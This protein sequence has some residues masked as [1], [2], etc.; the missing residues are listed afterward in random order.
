MIRKAVILA[1]G[2]SQRLFPLSLEIPKPLLTLGGQTLIE[3]VANRLRRF[4]CADTIYASVGYQSQKVSDQFVYVMQKANLKHG[5]FVD[6]TVPG[7]S[8][9]LFRCRDY[10]LTGDLAGEALWV[11]TV[12]NGI[13]VD[14][15]RAA[16]EFEKL[17]RP[18]CMIVPV[19][20]ESNDFT[21]DLFKGDDGSRISAISRRSDNLSASPNGLFMGSG[22]QLI[23][24]TRILQLVG[25]NSYNNFWELWQYLIEKGQLYVAKTTPYKWCKVD[26]LEDW[27]REIVSFAQGRSAYC[28]RD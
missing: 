9:W 6:E 4:A 28:T 12:D 8:Y 20:S 2:N 14:Y 5:V 25:E 21:G 7:T 17:N 26:T 24:P 13:Q 18:A 27:M 10:F 3:L 16:E 11:S 15:E 19:P 23:N 22:L 1:A